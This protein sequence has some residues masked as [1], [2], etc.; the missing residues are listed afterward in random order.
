MS[1]GKEKPPIE[2]PAIEK[3]PIKATVIIGTS[4]GVDV[5]SETGDSE[6]EAVGKALTAPLTDIIGGTI[7]DD[8]YWKKICNPPRF[9]IFRP[10][11]RK[12]YNAELKSILEK[13]TEVMR[14]KI[15][16]FRETTTFLGGSVERDIT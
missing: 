2:M 1:R 15:K 6:V 13:N 12:K 7:F 9:L 11:K 4:D 16:E 5:S 14:E 3:I 10:R 8:G